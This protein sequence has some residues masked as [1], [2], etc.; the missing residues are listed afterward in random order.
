MFSFLVGVVADAGEPVC[1]RC[2]S[3]RLKKLISRIS[4]IRSKESVLEDL[5][6]PGEIGDPNDPK[7]VSRW[8]KKMGS[9][10]G[11]E[12]GEDFDGSIDEMMENYDQESEEF[13]GDE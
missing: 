5:A 11:D 1:P 7:A 2:G 4:R 6:D 3:T 8:A 9:A 10:M 12:I 13:N